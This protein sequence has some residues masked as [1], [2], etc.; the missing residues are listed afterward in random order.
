MR[1]HHPLTAVDL[2]RC[3][4]DPRREV[5]MPVAGSAD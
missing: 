1:G 4:T 2:Y 5:L 3:G